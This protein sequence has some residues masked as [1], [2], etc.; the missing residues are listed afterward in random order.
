MNLVD[1]V[2]VPYTVSDVNRLP[3]VATYQL[4]VLESQYRQPLHRLVESHASR[5]NLLHIHRVDQACVLCDIREIP[6]MVHSCRRVESDFGLRALIMRRIVTRGPS[7]SLDGPSP[8]ARLIMCHVTLA[9]CTT[10]VHCEKPSLSVRNQPRRKTSQGERSFED[11]R[12][13]RGSVHQLRFQAAS[14]A[15]TSGKAARV[16]VHSTERPTVAAVPQML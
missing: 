6:R 14:S 12:H 9:L 2:S 3:F 16:R 5:S 8:Y 1:C 15:A 11:A 13:S 4:L 10:L 7:T